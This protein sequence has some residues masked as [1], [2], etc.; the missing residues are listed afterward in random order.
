M[1]WIY[2]IVLIRQ[3]HQ[4][5]NTYKQYYIDIIIYIY[6]QNKVSILTYL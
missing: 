1:L 4:F 5:Y 2:R 6:H 3:G